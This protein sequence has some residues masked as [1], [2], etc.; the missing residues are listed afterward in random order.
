MIAS[1]PMY[2]RPELRA[3]NDAFWVQIR[4][5]L[6]ARGLGAPDA[7]DLEI[8]VWDAWESP[9]LCFSQTCNMPYRTR[10][11][12][13]VTLI[14]AADY[15]LDGAAHGQ[16]YSEFVVR[17][18]DAGKRPEDFASARFAYNEVLSQSGWASAQNWAASR[19]FAFPAS[20]QT[21]AHLESARAVAEGRADIATI[22]AVTW[23]LLQRYEAFAEGL[24]SVGRTDQSPGLS[25]ITRARQ[26]PAPYRAAIT[27]AI[28][29]LSPEHRQAIGIK[30]VVAIPAAT[31]LAIPTPPAPKNGAPA[32]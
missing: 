17:S 3:A 31:Y 32:S 10:L 16:Y 30:A 1:L 11:H 14:G 27:S 29:A 19:G 12:A 18:G 15:G 6:R 8:G 13:A 25:F 28:A 20:L 4:D 7:L 23:R 9:D 21:G 22:D 24:I 5:G 2:T 26:D